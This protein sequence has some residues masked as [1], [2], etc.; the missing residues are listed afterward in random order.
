LKKELKKQMKAAKKAE[1]KRLKALKKKQKKKAR[2]ASGKQVAPNLKENLDMILALLKR[3]Y[4]VTRGRI[5]INFR[6]MHLRVASGDAAKTAILYG[7]I[8]QS[9][10]YILNFVEEKF[11]HVKRSPGAMSVEPDYTATQS[12]AEI[13][14][15]CKVKIRHAISIAVSMLMAYTKEHGRACRKAMLRQK[16]NRKNPA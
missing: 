14:L 7:V 4:E 13:D 5:G 12:G 2:I 9:V 8:V 10:S 6:K 16:E 15:I 11:T 3:L 1:Q